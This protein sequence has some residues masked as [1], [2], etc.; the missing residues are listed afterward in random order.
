MHLVWASRPCVQTPSHEERV[1]AKQKSLRARAAPGNPLVTVLGQLIRVAF[2]FL[3]FQKLFL[4]FH[5]VTRP[6]KTTVLTIRSLIP[7]Q[8]A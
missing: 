8:L 4:P 3:Q 1:V 7:K 2:F 5:Q 6:T